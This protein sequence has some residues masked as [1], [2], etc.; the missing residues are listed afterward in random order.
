MRGLRYVQKGSAI[1][2]E[3]S[4]GDFLDVSRLDL[5]DIGV[6]VLVHGLKL[7]S[8][9][10]QFHKLLLQGV[11]VVHCIAQGVDHRAAG[12]VHLSDLVLELP[13]LLHLL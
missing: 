8:V 4:R 7:V 5:G 11:Q 13:H 12:T 6:H 2:S 9:L 1:C 3:E 10:L